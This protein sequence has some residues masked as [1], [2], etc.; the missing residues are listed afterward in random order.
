MAKQVDTIRA[1]LVSL[2]SNNY[3]IIIPLS[4]ADSIRVEDINELRILQGKK[5]LI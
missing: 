2:A 4:I 1:L 3:Q 5:T